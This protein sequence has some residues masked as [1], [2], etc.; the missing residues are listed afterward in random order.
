MIPGRG[1]CSRSSRACYVPDSI[2][3]TWEVL[4]D[5]VHPGGSRVLSKAGWQAIGTAK[6]EWAKRISPHV[7]VSRNRSV[8]FQTFRRGLQGLAGMS[9]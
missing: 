6:H 3:G 7:D 9:R 8:S 5:A 1:S 4:A 2:C